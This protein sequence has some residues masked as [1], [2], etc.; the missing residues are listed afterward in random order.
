MTLEHELF[1]RRQR[2]PDTRGVPRA[3]SPVGTRWAADV[4]GVAA[5]AL[6]R[7]VCAASEV[8]HTRKGDFAHSLRNAS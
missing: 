6:L 8:D 2:S 4:D 3:A 1:S 5:E 7:G